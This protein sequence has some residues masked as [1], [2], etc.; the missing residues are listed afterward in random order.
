MQLKYNVD[1]VLCIDATGSMAHIID[2]VKQNAINLYNDIHQ[3]MEKRRKH[4]HQMRVRVVA[5]RDYL[6]DGKD[7]ML[8]SNF[9]LLPDQAADLQACVESIYAD[10]GGDIPEDGLEALAYAIKSD[11]TNEGLKKRHIV[12]VWSDAP[13]HDIGYGSSSPY[14][15]KGMPESF[16]ELSTWWD[17]KQM[18]GFMNSN[19]KRLILFAPNAPA[20]NQIS[21]V[22]DQVIHVQ[23]VSEGLTEVNYQQVLDVVSNSI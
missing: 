1:L 17:D 22:W 18:G 20:W 11:W 4:I 9:F 12:V 8:T 14:Y 13:T 2:I 16:S 7:A 15:P 19:A 5:F 21:A 3:E 23:T 10:G 6:E